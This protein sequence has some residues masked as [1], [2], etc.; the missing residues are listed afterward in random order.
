MK[1]R[2]LY[3][4]LVSLFDEIPL[5]HARQSDRGREDSTIAV[6]KAFVGMFTSGEDAKCVALFDSTMKMLMPESKVK[7]ARDSVVARFGA[8]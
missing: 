1:R 3:V 4:A 5:L 6:A 7:E 8:F 2:L